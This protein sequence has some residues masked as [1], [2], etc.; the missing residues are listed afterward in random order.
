[1]KTNKK[2]NTSKLQEGTDFFKI[3]ASYLKQKGHTIG[4]Y[5]KVFDY[6]A[7]QL[8]SFFWSAMPYTHLLRWVLSLKGIQ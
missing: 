4:K 6:H 3:K 1:M 5:Y 8:C 2:K 7:A